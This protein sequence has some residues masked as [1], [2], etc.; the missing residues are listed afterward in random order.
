MADLEGGVAGFAFASGLAAISTVLELLDSGDHL[1]AS[2]DLYGGTFRLLERVRD[3]FGRAAGQ[4]FVNLSDIDAGARRHPAEH[5]ADLGG[6]ADQ[7][8]AASGGPRRP[9]R[10]WGVSAGC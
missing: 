1:I 6:N 5:Q 7:S 4:V 8:H 9:W 2:D 10:R 3:A